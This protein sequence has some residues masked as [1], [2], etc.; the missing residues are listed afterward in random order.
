[1][2]PGPE[3][4]IRKTNS[5]G[6]DFSKGGK[7]FGKETGIVGGARTTGAVYNGVGGESV[8]RSSERKGTQK[9]RET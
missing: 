4:V 6:N 7:V 5:T 3:Q 2:Q 8:A 9:A 1:M